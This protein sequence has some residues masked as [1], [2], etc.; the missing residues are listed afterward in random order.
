MNDIEEQFCFLKVPVSFVLKVLQ[1]FLHASECS[2]LVLCSL[3]FG[4]V[5]FGGKN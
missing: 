2:F 3:I 1:M 5:H 4:K